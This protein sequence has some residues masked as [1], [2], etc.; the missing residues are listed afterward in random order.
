MAG[1]WGNATTIIIIIPI[2]TLGELSTITITITNGDTI[3]ITITITNGDTTIIID[4]TLG[5]RCAWGP[6]HCSQR[7]SPRGGVLGISAMML[8]VNMMGMVR[9]IRMVRMMHY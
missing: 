1:M 7:A 5:E 9:M 6:C 3:I 4:P 8:R 2:L